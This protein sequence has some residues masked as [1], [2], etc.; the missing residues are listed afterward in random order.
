MRRAL[1]VPLLV[2]ACGLTGC[3]G[4]DTSAPTASP[5]REAT[6]TISSSPTPTKPTSTPRKPTPVTKV[7]VVIEENHSLDQ[8]S[9]GMPYTFG[10]AKRFGYANRY[11]A[12]RHPSLPNYIAIAGGGTFGIADDGPPSDH[13]IH[14]PSVFGRAIASGHT[15]ALYADG[16]PEPCAVDNGGTR[17]AVKHNP[18]AYFAD[19]RAACRRHDLPVSRIGAAIRSGGLPDVGM[20][21]PNLCNDAHDCDLSVADR[22]FRGLM[23]QVFA[24]PDWRSGR[25]AVVL[26]ADEDE[27]ENQGNTVLT[28]VMHRSQR[29]R[30]V[31][32][33]LTHYSLS[34][35]LSLVTGTAPLGEARTAPSMADA[36][37][38]P[39]T[40]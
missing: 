32:T 19:E 34:G 10:L 3:G 13:P 35:L 7:L 38:L 1:L 27:H 37:R 31:T 26:T 12:I 33:P 21:I 22:W 29:A 25:L 14:A 24:G 8:M 15:A 6:E 36:F 2:L 28:V 18:W 11:T 16:M 9:A 30:V 17:Y 5:S 39:L 40:K 23:E 4:G 20:V